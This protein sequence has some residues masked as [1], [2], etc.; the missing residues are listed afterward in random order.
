MRVRVRV[1]VCVCVK[2][3]EEEGGWGGGGERRW[4][5]ADKSFINLWLENQ[6]FCENSS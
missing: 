4:E 6:Q 1:R 5:L 3:V 2:G